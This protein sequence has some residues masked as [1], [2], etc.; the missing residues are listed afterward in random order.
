MSRTFRR[1]VKSGPRI[2][3]TELEFEVSIILI[4]F[5]PLSATSMSSPS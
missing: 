3:L 5:E 2:V 4:E 1:L